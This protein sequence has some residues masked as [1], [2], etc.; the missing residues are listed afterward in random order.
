LPIISITSGN[1]LRAAY[2]SKNAIGTLLQITSFGFSA[3][4]YLTAYDISDFK[5][6]Y[7]G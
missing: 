5:Y 2:L 4:S 3:S 1:K 7:S 6:G